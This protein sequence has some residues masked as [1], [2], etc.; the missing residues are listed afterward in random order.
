MDGGA[1]LI[2]SVALML[3]R[4]HQEMPPENLL[5]IFSILRVMKRAHQRI[6]RHAR[7]RQ[8]RVILF[9]IEHLV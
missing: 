7:L 6:F 3:D 1:W 4:R 2:Q 8:Q 5:Q 9:Q